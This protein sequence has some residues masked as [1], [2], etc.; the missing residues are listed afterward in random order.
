MNDT[1]VSHFIEP[2]DY[3]LGE[4]PN[5]GIIKSN[6]DVIKQLKINEVSEEILKFFESKD[7]SY[8]FVFLS[9]SYGTGK[10]TF[11]YRLL[12]NLIDSDSE[13]LVY[14][15]TDSTK[16]VYQYISDLINS[17]TETKKIIFYCDHS[18]L[19]LDFKKLRELRG[20]LSSMQFPDKSIML[21]QSIR[22]NSLEKFR[23][24]VNNE[25]E[26]FH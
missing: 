23:K 25:I 3:Y 12:K 21:L 8:P 13:L 20:Y 24:K 11:T 1:Y 17:L 18:E 5:F 15:I 2:K 9:G 26:L 4:E 19:D 10:S 7:I 22:E 6:Y 16:I 14:E